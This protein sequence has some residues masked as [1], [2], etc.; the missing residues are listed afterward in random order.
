MVTIPTECEENKLK[1]KLHDVPNIMIT[2][3]H[4]IPRPDPKSAAV[5]SGSFASVRK[6]NY[7]DETKCFFFNI[8]FFSHRITHRHSHESLLTWMRVR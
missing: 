4:Q 8:P 3:E 1:T 2:N 5:E 7:F 6:K